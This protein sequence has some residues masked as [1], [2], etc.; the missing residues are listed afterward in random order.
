MIRIIIAIWALCVT[1]F[2]WFAQALFRA[3]TAA[4]R[5]QEEGVK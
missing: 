1:P 4:E 2:F 5:Q 3:G